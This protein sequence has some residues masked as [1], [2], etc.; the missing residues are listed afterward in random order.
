MELLKL[1]TKQL[2]FYDLFNSTNFVTKKVRQIISLQKT[3]L[4]PLRRETNHEKWGKNRDISFCD[5][6]LA[7]FSIANFLRSG[8]I[9]N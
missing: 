9:Q 1:G 5:L 8:F 4:F 7:F 6:E 3:R 2:N